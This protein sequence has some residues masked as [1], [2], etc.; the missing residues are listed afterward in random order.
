[1]PIL[2]C[3]FAGC[4]YVT[5]DFPSAAVGAI[6][7][8]HTATHTNFSTSAK[9]EKVRRPTITSG[10]TS[11]QWIYFQSKWVEYRDATKIKGRELIIQL[12]ECCDE[13]LQVNLFRINGSQKDDPE[14]TVI[15]TIR[16][17]AVHD[18][19][20][21][22]SRATLSN[23]KQDRDEP[24]RHYVAR[25]QGQAATCKFN[26]MAH[27]S[28]CNSDIPKD[29][30]DD[31][32]RDALTLGIC[33]LDI[34]QDLLGKI[35]QNMTL[36]QVTTF[37]AN[38]E[39]AKKSA[40]H[41]SGESTAGAIRSSYRRGNLPATGNPN[42]RVGYGNTGN[43]NPRVGYGNTGNPNPRV[44]YGNQNTRNNTLKT[45]KYC[46]QMGHN[47]SDPVVRQRECPAYGK[48]C[49]KCRK[50]GHYA[51]VC[52]SH[53]SQQV[54]NASAITNELGYEHPAEDIEGA[55][56]QLCTLNVNQ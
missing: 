18:E 33:D 42:P 56:F 38:K 15:A 32:V 39:K 30:T 53:P 49:P 8:N 25:L 44:G 9:V 14:A 52:R 31:I 23:M 55:I 12:I 6:L 28:T 2:P 22:I 34:R 35:D 40:T 1:M 46:G 36:E 13:A 47:G 27:C 50:R 43:P 17:L 19:N 4:D 21:M 26:T 48:P 20:I 16:K 7:N 3:D 54:P 51:N 29:Y 41:L 11:Q 5:G 10:I 24:V 37:I 45:C